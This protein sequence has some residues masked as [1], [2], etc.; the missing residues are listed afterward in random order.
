MR[1]C[2]INDIA[3]VASEL[4][5]GLEERGHEV[6]VIQPDLVGGSLPKMLKPLVAPARAVEWARIARQVSS[7]H[8]DVVHIHYAYL[9]MIGVLGRF[10]YILHCHGSDVRDMAPYSRPMV[11]RALAAAKHV[12]YST[13]DLAQYILPIR[14][15]AEFLPNPIDTETF[16]PL[17]EPTESTDVLICCALTEV[18]GADVILEACKRLARERPDIRIT[19][20]EGGEYTEAFRAL[21]NVTV[22]PHQKRADLPRLIA[23][24]GIA[25]GQVRLGAVGMAELEAMA[26]GRPVVAWFNENGSYD[27]PPPF[28]NA[29]DPE[30]IADAVK[31]LASAPVAREVMGLAGREWVIEHHDLRLITERVERTAEQLTADGRLAVAAAR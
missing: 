4:A 21:P 6:P 2:E 19:A 7:G 25:I 27:I 8:F 30:S 23:E 12:Y 11:E 31:R 15:D 20:I 10:P 17:T 18:K 16:R 5:R 1:I 3:S 13:P 28:L 29:H 22:I 9:G 24:H 26:C 14:P